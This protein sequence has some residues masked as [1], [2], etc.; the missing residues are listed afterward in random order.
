MRFENTN[1]THNKWYEIQVQPG[2]DDTFRVFTSW[3]PM[4]SD[5]VKHRVIYEGK[6]DGAMKAVEKK[7][8]DR[9]RHGYTQIE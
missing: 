3:G 8:K 2:P 6:I 9:I 1:G 5:L 4:G 7:R